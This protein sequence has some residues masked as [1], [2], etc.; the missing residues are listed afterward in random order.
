MYG[1]TLP[2]WMAGRYPKSLPGLLQA[3]S[4]RLSPEDRKR[5]AHHLS[6]YARAPA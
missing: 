1:W 2:T 5:V 4:E 6:R 3:L